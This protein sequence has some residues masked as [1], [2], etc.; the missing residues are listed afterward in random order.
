MGRPSSPLACSVAEDGAI[1]ARVGG[2]CAA[3]FSG[4]L[5]LRQFPRQGP[6]GIRPC[7]FQGL[8]SQLDEIGCSAGRG[9]LIVRGFA[10]GVRPSLSSCAATAAGWRRSEALDPS[11]WIVA[12]LG[13]GAG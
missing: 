7:L 1:R 3:M 2:R 12:S 8:G 13:Q 10:S 4:V 6:R 5:N 11:R 9:R